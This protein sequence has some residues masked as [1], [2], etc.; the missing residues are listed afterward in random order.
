MSLAETLLLLILIVVLGTSL[1]ALLLLCALVAPRLVAR[2]RLNVERMPIRSFFVG[3]VNLLFFGVLA[4]GLA[5]SNPVARATALLIVVV[6]FWCMALGLAAAAQLVGERLHLVR[7]GPIRELLLG[8]LLLQGAALV[9]V[10]GWFG[11]TTVALLTGYGAA[12]I[13]LIRRGTELPAQ[14]PAATVDTSPLE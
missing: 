5:E 2:A 12:V 13:A 1:A 10:V 14:R 3:L 6:L 4:A 11:V 9:P 8:A 7:G